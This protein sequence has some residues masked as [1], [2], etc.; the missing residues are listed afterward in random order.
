MTT[1]TFNNLSMAT[2]MSNI[3]NSNAPLPSKEQGSSSSSADSYT[4]PYASAEF[5]RVNDINSV[6]NGDEV[7]ANSR[8]NSSDKPVFSPKTESLSG[9]KISGLD[10]L[11]KRGWF[12]PVVISSGIGVLLVG[13]VIYAF[14]GDDSVQ[15]IEGSSA[16][17]AQIDAALNGRDNLNTT[18][19]QF[20]VEQDRIKAQAQA[21]EGITNAAIITSA[22]ANAPRDTFVDENT[23]AMNVITHGQQGAPKTTA[24]LSKDKSLVKNTD[25]DGNI[26]FTN[27]E[28]GD[29][30]VPSDAAIQKQ[31]ALYNQPAS[32]PQAVYNT[33]QPTGQGGYNQGGNQNYNNNNYDGSGGGYGNTYQDQ[34]SQ[35][36]QQVAQPDMYL[37]N[38]R[39]T[40]R[41]EYD[42]YAQQQT[43]NQS[44]IQQ[45]NEMLKQQQQQL[46]QQRQGLVDN[47]FSSAVGSQS[48]ASQPAS[49]FSSV[50]YNKPTN[51]SGNIGNNPNGA[52]P[53]QSAGGNNEFGTNGNFGGGNN[54]QGGDGINGNFGGGNNYQGGDATNFFPQNTPMMLPANNGGNALYQNSPYQN[55]PQQGQGYNTQNQNGLD[56]NG[57]LPSHVLRAGTSIPVMITKSV[58]SDEG[59]R[60]IGE[61]VSGKFAG[62]KVYGV[63]APTARSVGV[64][65]TR[66]APPN[67]RKP[68]MPINAM[69]TALGSQK[70][71]IATDIK[72]HYGRN[73]GV[74][75]LTSILEGYGSAYEGA[76]QTSIVTDSGSI[77]TVKSNE[78][79]SDQIRGEVIG[80][81][82]TRLTEDVSKLGSRPPTFLIAQGTVVNMVLNN[83]L[84][85]TGV[86]TDIA[87]GQ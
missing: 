13:S 27:S 78:I 6:P 54:Y 72:R 15:Y 19:A 4:T 63:I 17:S 51:Q 47:S 26:T 1:M 77:V 18:Q 59:N 34:N 2:N 73:Y 39:E 83:N 56:A 35:Q 31:S 61:V 48:G 69:A 11:Y 16:N 36:Q 76:G 38:T 65:F 33:S 7:I 86:A 43:E 40:L 75:A 5:N 70:E 8:N 58:N 52:N 55:L 37:Q 22:E 3:L 62:S 87:A 29:I 80:S 74:L 41:T 44:N 21:Q 45:R 32:N 20:L 68:I 14:T 84:D 64:L 82:G 24:E 30:F 85:T 12:R 9:H 71:A 28:T 60:V 10:P 25:S 79:D 53:N 67:P 46:Y 81:L 50:N 66:L 42:V 23:S 57:R 49:G